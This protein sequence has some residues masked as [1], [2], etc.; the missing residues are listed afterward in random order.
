MWIAVKKKGL[1]ATRQLQCDLWYIEAAAQC[2]IPKITCTLCVVVPAPQS[3]TLS[4]RRAR[5]VIECQ[6]SKLALRGNAGFIEVD[7]TKGTLEY[8]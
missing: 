4:S 7:A 8:G 2:I 3:V 6:A 1:N 5:I